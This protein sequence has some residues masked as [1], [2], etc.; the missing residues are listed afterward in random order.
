MK[1]LGLLLFFIIY[2]FNFTK[3]YDVETKQLTEKVLVVNKLIFGEENIEH[4][5]NLI[6]GTLAVETMYGRYKRN[7]P[8]G[9]SQISIDGWGFIQSRLREEDLEIIK[10]IGYDNS[11]VKFEDLATDHLLAVMYC[12]FYYKYKLKGKVPKN[13]DEYAN[14]WKKYYN[15]SEGAGTENDFKEKYKIYGKKY[16][17]E[18]HLITRER[19]QN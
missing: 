12:A 18:F 9:I 11:K 10:L 3:K 16:L 1:K 13:L 2:S 8:L 19:T 4:Y 15:T 5:N 14:T 17:D 7:S 6:V